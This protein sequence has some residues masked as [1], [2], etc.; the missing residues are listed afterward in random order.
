MAK[1]PPYN[2]GFRYAYVVWFRLGFVTRSSRDEPTSLV[3]SPFRL[4]LEVVTSPCRQ[5]LNQQDGEG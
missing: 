2:F 4:F 5:L 3:T 1:Q